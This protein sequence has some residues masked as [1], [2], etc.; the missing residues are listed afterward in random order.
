MDWRGWL[1]I[2]GSVIGIGT[3][4]F[5]WV[6]G[7][8][9]KAMEEGRSIQR[10]QVVE[11]TTGELKLATDGLKTKVGN[12]ETNQASMQ[13]DIKNIYNIQARIEAGQVRIEKILLDDRKR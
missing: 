12:L 10:L 5:T 3:G 8:G 7:Y 11:Q 6:S 4:V 2:L 1:A 9:A 13:T